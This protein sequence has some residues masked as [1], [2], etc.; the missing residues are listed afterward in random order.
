ML[1]NRVRGGEPDVP[2]EYAELFRGGSSGKGDF[3]PLAEVRAAFQRVQQE[4]LKL[5]ELPYELGMKYGSSNS[6]LAEG[7]MFIHMHRGWHNGKIMTL[8][9]LVGKPIM[10]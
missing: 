6:S 9:A 3:P 7:L 5:T 4:V 1:V 8:R 10:Y 2:A